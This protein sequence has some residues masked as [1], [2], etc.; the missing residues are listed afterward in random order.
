LFKTHK[1][2]AFH[3]LKLNGGQSVIDK[4]LLN[5]NDTILCSFKAK[6]WGRQYSKGNFVAIRQRPIDKMIEFG[7][8]QTIIWIGKEAY[9]LVKLFET[10]CQDNSIHAYN[11]REEN[12]SKFIAVNVS[13]LMD[14]HPLDGCMPFE[15]HELY[16]KLKYAIVDIGGQ[17]DKH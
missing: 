17:L 6:I 7:Q 8:V 13:E 4:F 9:L 15:D 14:Y 1:S 12:E 5:P 10:I 3:L 16:V 2:T 11:L